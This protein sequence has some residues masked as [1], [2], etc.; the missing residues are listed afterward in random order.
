[1]TNQFKHLAFNELTALQLYQIIQL[2][3]EVFV[4]EQK[5]PYNDTDDKDL[6]AQHVVLY[7]ADG[8]LIAHARILPPGISYAGYA[9]IGRVVVKAMARKDGRGI[10]LMKYCV[11]VCNELY[12]NIPIKISVQKYLEKFYNDLGFATV[13]DV[14]MEDE[15]EHVGMVYKVL[16]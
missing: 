2:R 16:N 9:S 11:Q 8:V 10:A 14:Y 7:N 12:G 3:I 4:L 1:M 6:V 15:I 5:C 13:T